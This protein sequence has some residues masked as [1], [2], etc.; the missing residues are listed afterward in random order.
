MSTLHIVHGDQKFTNIQLPQYSSA[1]NSL[2]ET[3]CNNSIAHFCQY[4]LCLRGF[5]QFLSDE[6]NQHRKF[7]IFFFLG[8][9]A[10]PVTQSR[11]QPGTQPRPSHAPRWHVPGANRKRAAAL[12][13]QREVPW[14]R[15]PPRRVS[16]WICRR[17]PGRIRRRHQ[18]AQPPDGALAVAGPR[19]AAP[20]TGG[21]F[22][23][24]RQG[25]GGEP[26]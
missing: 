24:S 2:H 25:H 9:A 11:A 18:S 8:I 16:P 5:N 1:K 23:E 10:A 17:R 22:L 4:T 21:C 6:E 15:G 26:G 20:C 12:W 7:T 19:W 14:R 13:P 3:K